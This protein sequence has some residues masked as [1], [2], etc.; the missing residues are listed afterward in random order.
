MQPKNCNKAHEIEIFPKEKLSWA[1]LRP[2]FKLRRSL[3]FS[4]NVCSGLEKKA[5][6]IIF[7]LHL[8]INTELSTLYSATMKDL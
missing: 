5:L 7:Q 1:I 3:T 6:F 8:Q 4:Q 2:V